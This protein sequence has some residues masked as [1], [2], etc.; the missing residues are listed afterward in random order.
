LQFQS[1]EQNKFI[2]AVNGTKCYTYSLL[3]KRI[4]HNLFR[5][6][7]VVR[8]MEICCIQN[9]VIIIIVHCAVSVIDLVDVDSAH[10]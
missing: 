3:R 2:L 8:E 6:Y 10:K 4:L 1:T 5:F 7:R 9:A